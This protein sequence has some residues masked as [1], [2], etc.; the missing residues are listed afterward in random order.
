[1]SFNSRKLCK[2]SGA[3]VS[4]KIPRLTLTHDLQYV[5]PTIAL[6]KADGVMRSGQ[7]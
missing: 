7:S 6:I 1:M 3:R 2:V 4:P 5:L